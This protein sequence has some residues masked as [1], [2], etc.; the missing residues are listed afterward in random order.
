MK[1]YILPILLSIIGIN[2]AY[3]Q[4]GFHIGA[5]GS[6]NNT[7]VLNQNNFSNLYP[8]VDTIIRTSELDYKLTWGYTA[9]VAL[10]YNFNHM[11]GIES[12]VVVTGTG[13]RYE[14][15][16]QGPAVLGIKPYGDNTPEGRVK[17]TRDVRLTYVQIPVMFKFTSKKGRVGKFYGMLGPQFGFRISAKETLKLEE[18]EYA[19]QLRAKDKFRPVDIGL[20]LQL[21]ADIYAT[22]HLYFNVGLSLYGGLMDTNGKLL[23]EFPWHSQND[24][25]Y[26]KTYHFR[27]GLI[28]GVHYIIGEGRR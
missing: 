20:A 1:K 17:V 2:G 12:Q 6:V 5:V 19:P 9:G 23:R 28:A 3:A 26:Q 18:D 8:F 4:K 25:G 24:P 11:L 10:G 15:K 16:L 13:Q 21:G 22:D 14:D 27:G 7:W